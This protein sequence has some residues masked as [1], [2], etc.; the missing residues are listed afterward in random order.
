MP[1]RF[2]DWEGHMSYHQYS[3]I[4]H[5]HCT[6]NTPDEGIECRD[7]EEQFPPSINPVDKA[8]ADI[9]KSPWS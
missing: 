2:Q 8:T 9:V 7:E 3:L 4:K 1:V 6:S 5:G